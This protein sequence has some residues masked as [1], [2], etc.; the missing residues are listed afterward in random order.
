MWPCL[1]LSLS[2]SA[3]VSDVQE[4]CSAINCGSL[5]PT[6]VKTY[7]HGYRLKSSSISAL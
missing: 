5:A 2:P 1:S 7:R 3:T 6:S 4:L